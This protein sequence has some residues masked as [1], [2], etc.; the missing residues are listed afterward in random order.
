[1]RCFSGTVFNIQTKLY[2]FV[3]QD[4]LC[5]VAKCTTIAIKQQVYYND[6]KWKKSDKNLT[7][8]E[9]VDRLQLSMC[10]KA[11]NRKNNTEIRFPYFLK[12]FIC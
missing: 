7:L 2:L 9:I 6:E 11:E 10:E 1:M 3:L 12:Y 5:S 8:K 4:L